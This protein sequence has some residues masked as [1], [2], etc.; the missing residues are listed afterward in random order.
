MN[1]QIKTVCKTAK[2]RRDN[3]C[4]TDIQYC[5]T[6]ERRVKLDSGLSGQPQYWNPKKRCISESLP[7]EIGD[8]VFLNKKL[9]NEIRKP[10]II[11]FGLHRN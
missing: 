2:I 8:R 9:N 11:S 1:L 3:T 4:I 7:K 6:N 10:R 5:F